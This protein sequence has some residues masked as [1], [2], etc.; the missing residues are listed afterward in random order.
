MSLSLQNV[1]KSFDASSIGLLVF[2]LVVFLI[3]VFILFP[4]LPVEHRDVLTQTHRKLGLEPSQS[5]LKTQRSAD[6]HQ[7]QPGKLAKIQ[8]LHI[9]PIKS[10]RGIELK[11]SIVLAKGMEL[12]RMYCFA[13]LK[14]AHS[15]IPG[16]TDLQETH[17]W[18]LATLRQLPLL[19]NVVVDLWLPDPTKKSRLL[20][21]IQGGFLVVRFP[22]RHAGLLGIIQTVAAKLSRGWSAVSEKEFM[23]PLEFPTHQEI[24]DNG[25]KYEDL[26]FFKETANA[27]NMSVQLPK[28][29]E[30][31][32][33]ARYTVGLFRTDPSR[34]RKAYSCAPSKEQVGYE[35][36]IDFQDEVRR[37]CPMF[38]ISLHDSIC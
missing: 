5:N 37:G 3:P 17:R 7:P 11:E 16:I 18:E 4:P 32:L 30:H 6:L 38:L 26:K 19:A 36:V 20:G 21:E 8:S 2:T 24:Q 28:E 34:R 31:Y 29:L 14:P 27:L 10:C 9:Y 1:A 22:W 12:D 15:P 35:A 13:Q 23:L 25:Y 33:G